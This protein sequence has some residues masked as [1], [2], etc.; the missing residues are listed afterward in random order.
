MLIGSQSERW[1][2]VWLFLSLLAGTALAQSVQQ[3]PLQ[4]EIL[5]CSC[6]VK[7]FGLD[8]I[9][10]F[11]D[12]SHISKAMDVLKK[13]QNTI[14]VYLKLRHN[15]LPK[16]PGFVFLGLEI[17]HLT[18]HNSSLAVVEETSLTSIGKNCYYILQG[19]KLGLYLPTIIIDST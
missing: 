19:N 18:I 7:K 9:C 2:M 6:S 4:K 10:E 13:R 16:L 1:R 5:P 3:C 8:I 14:I 17:I 12:F 11:A 15:N